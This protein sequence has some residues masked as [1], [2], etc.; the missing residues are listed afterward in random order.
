MLVSRYDHPLLKETSSM[1]TMIEIFA[2]VRDEGLASA[3][4]E[5]RL[6]GRTRMIRMIVRQARRR[7]GPE[8]ARRLTR[9]LAGADDPDRLEGVAEAVIDCGGGGEFLDRVGALLRADQS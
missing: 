7:F 9:L 6:E 3:R 4:N 2:Q 8:T 5:G 1:A